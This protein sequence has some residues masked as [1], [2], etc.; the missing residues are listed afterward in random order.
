MT[1]PAKNCDNDNLAPIKVSENPDGSF[2]LEW[3]ETHPNLQ[4]LNEMT[5]TEIE[6]WFNKAIEDALKSYEDHPQA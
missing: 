6:E 1:D 5:P 4:F 3:D 2:T